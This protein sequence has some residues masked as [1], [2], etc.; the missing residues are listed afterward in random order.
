MCVEVDGPARVVEI[1]WIVAGACAGVCAL[2]ATDAV[3][4]TVT[5]DDIGAGR[6]GS[7]GRREQWSVRGCRWVRESC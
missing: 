2:V 7:G 1:V 4:V 6:W 5:V 3:L